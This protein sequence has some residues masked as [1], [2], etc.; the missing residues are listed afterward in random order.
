MRRALATAVQFLAACERELPVLVESLR[1]DPEP[2]A[3]DRQNLA[4]LLDGL[5]SLTRLALELPGGDA[6]RRARLSTSL[7][8]LARVLR[9]LDVAR[10]E[11]RF[12]DAAELLGARVVPEL[13][14]WRHLF[15]SHLEAMATLPPETDAP[16]NT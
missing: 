10:G 14:G 15:A 11:T 5:E 16:G 12:G 1:G 2:S 8:G 3:A 9:D 7:G 13:R 6:E 4:H